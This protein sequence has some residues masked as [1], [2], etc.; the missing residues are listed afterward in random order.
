MIYVDVLPAF[1]VY[2]VVFGGGTLLAR[3][4]HTGR[5]A[6]PYLWRVLVAST[7]GILSAN[8]LLWI[9]VVTV[10]SILTVMDP[11]DLARPIVPPV[12]ELLLHPMPASLIGCIAG[13]ASGVV[14]GYL[15]SRGPIHPSRNPNLAA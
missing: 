7:V 5:P 6:V 4:T 15:A 2:L 9:I 14:W 12:L 11:S 10:G 3:I 1:I 13:I 8:A